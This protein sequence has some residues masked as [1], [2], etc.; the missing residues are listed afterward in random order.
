MAMSAHKPF[1]TKELKKLEDEVIQK[2]I[3][4]SEPY[5]TIRPLPPQ[6]FLNK[7][8]LLNPEF[9]VPESIKTLEEYDS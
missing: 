3:P 9:K 6:P 7:G 2:L 1:Y 5:A 8:R 4:E